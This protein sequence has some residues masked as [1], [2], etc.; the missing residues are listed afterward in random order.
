MD[1]LVPAVGTSAITTIESES[2]VVMDDGAQ[3]FV[4][5]SGRASHLP[6]VVAVHGAPGVQSHAD[7][8][9]M[10]GF[11]EDDRLL[12]TFDARGSGRSDSAAPLTMQRWAQD[13]EVIRRWLGASQ[14]VLVG[15]SYGGFIALDYACRYPA[16]LAGLIVVNSAADG[17]TLVEQI[18]LV[19]ATVSDDTKRDQLERLFSGRTESDTDLW[20]CGQAIVS[21]S[22]PDFIPS[23]TAP[24]E[25]WLR[26]TTHNE[27]FAFALPAYH[28]ERHLGRVSCPAL[29]CAGQLDLLI[30]SAICAAIGHGIPG[31]E[32]V[33][34]EYSGHNPALDEPK[35]FREAVQKFMGQVL[36]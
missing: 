36:A 15:H 7:S 34:F 23:V 4:R 19:I 2:R 35:R 27:A 1:T 22:Y 12:V 13:I 14:I 6:P 17:A 31:A 24:P 29:V 25:V 30:P 3:L 26:H 16:Q 18:R 9:G 21:L 11:L 28:V 8:A 33:K 20:A 32:V 10:W 5:R